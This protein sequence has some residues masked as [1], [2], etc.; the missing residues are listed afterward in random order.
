[1]KPV[2]VVFSRSFSASPDF[3]NIIQ[4]LLYQSPV[5]K[6]VAWSHTTNC[7]GVS[8]YNPPAFKGWPHFKSLT[9]FLCRTESGQPH[10]GSKALCNGPVR[11]ITMIISSCFF[12]WQRKYNPTLP[13]I[14][15]RHLSNADRNLPI[16]IDH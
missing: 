2:A 10:I 5:P 15:Y 14:E 8:K 1:M 13:R 4:G 7:L 6:W 16:G 12:L 11:L 3:I 9:R